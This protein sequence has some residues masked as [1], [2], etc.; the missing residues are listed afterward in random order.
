MLSKKTAL[1]LF[2]ATAQYTQAQDF[3]V[4]R[5]FKWADKIR[6][7]HI[8]LTAGA[9]RYCGDL[10]DRYAFDHLQLSWS[11]KLHLSYRLAEKVSLRTDIV[12]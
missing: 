12:L 7:W 8:G 9:T 3:K 5:A 4:G 11:A 1:L 10:S 6:D 2:L